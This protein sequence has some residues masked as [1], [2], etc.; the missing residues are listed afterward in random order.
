[1]LAKR[2]FK[3]QITI[4]KAVMA[5]FEGVDY[6][7]VRTE[8]SEIVLRPVSVKPQSEELE[9]IRRKI[10]ALGVTENDVEAAVRWARRRPGR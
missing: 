3:N 10:Q 8:D 7:D 6:F 2:T 4:P 9:S 5:G 1:M